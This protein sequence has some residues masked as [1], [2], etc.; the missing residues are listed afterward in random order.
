M[1]PDGPAVPEALLPEIAAS[2]VFVDPTAGMAPIGN[3]EDVDPDLV[4]LIRA[5]FDK[6]LAPYRRMR[7]LGVRFVNG[8]DAGVGPGKPHDVLSYAVEHS[9][10]F[11]LTPAD[12]LATVTSLAAEAAGVDDRKGFVRP[13]M[14][15]DLLVIHGDPAADITALRAVRA[16]F[17]SGKQITRRPDRPR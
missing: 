8:S 5:N 2:G 1:T 17:R 14:D 11:G 7:D 6:L 10:R 9:L 15:A 13:G 12:A 3:A 16:V 4:A